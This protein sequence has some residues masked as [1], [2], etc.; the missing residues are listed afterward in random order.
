MTDDTNETDERIARLE[1]DL[2]ELQSLVAAL[3]RKVNT[4]ADGGAS[5]LDGLDRFDRPVV[6]RAE[7]YDGDPS[8]QQLVTWYN[9]AGVRDSSKVRERI[10]SLRRRGYL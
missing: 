4:V 5:E 1:S 6:E 7:V 10:K 3:R 2:E 9:E 8:P